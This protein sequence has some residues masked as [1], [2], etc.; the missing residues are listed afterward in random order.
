MKFDIQIGTGDRTILDIGNFHLREK[1][2]TFLFG[3]SGIG[4]SLLARGIYGLLDGESLNVEV[5][6]QPYSKY[7]Q[8]SFCQEVR[9]YGFFVFQE[10]SSHLNPLMRISDQLHEG[11]LNSPALVDETLTSL[12]PAKENKQVENLINIYPQA[13]RPSGGEKQR[14]LLAMAISKLKLSRK[15][16]AGM[17]IFDEPT[18]SLD[19]KNRNIFL[20]LIF[21]EFKKSAKTILFISHDYSIIN[22][23]ETHAPDLKQKITFSELREEGNGHAIHPFSGKIYIEWIT[24]LKRQHHTTSQRPLLTM[25][26]GFEIFGKRYAFSKDPAFSRETHLALFPKQFLYLKADSGIGK[27][28]LA[29]ILIG[30]YRAS[31][32]K[33]QISDMKI[34]DHTPRIFWKKHVWAKKIGMIFQHADESLNLNS[35]VMDVFAGLPGDK[36]PDANQVLKQLEFFFDDEISDS[37]L[38][39]KIR[40][41]SGG[42]KQR[43]NILR[44]FFLETEII[45]LDEP[46]NGLDFV[47]IKKI[48]DI[49]LQKREEEKGI[50]IISHNEEIFDK[51]IPKDCRY[52]LKASQTVP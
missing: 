43:L 20:N 6:N 45:I 28:T 41:L 5:N 44:T 34:D 3:E 9:K 32:L 52:Y 2:I 16:S 10:P 12:W 18:G 38:K 23:I 19:N 8:S 7:L 39:Q 36:R 21:E 1:E 24:G 15:I 50:L 48:I 35:T 11:D 37:F 25:E 42:Q 4:K 14:I 46:L 31:R 40:Y 30:L 51:L 27:T 26:S 13:Y 29:K 17:Y 22:Y 33:I 49:I 47:S